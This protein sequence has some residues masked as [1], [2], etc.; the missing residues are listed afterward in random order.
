MS[1]GSLWGSDGCCLESTCCFM[2]WKEDTCEFRVEV[3][4]SEVEDRESGVV[5]CND[6]ADEATMDEG[7]TV[8]E[9][10]EDE[11]L[12]ECLLDWCLVEREELLEGVEDDV[13][14]CL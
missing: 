12:D 3:E 14:G 10:E 9:D 8:D 2:D 7:V 1:T 6:T 13:D 11:R 5:V 4:W